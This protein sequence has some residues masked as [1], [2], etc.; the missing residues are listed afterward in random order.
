MQEVIKPLTSECVRICV[1][2]I[3]TIAPQEVVK[4]NFQMKTSPLTI[5]QTSSPPLKFPPQT[6]K[7]QNFTRSGPTKS[8]ISYKVT[9]ST[10]ERPA[11]ISVLRCARSV[12]SPIITSIPICG[13]WT[14]LNLLVD[15]SALG[16]NK[17]GTFM[18]LKIRLYKGCMGKV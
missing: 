18:I 4:P 10:T 17:P 5:L 11:L 8:W 14:S 1:E 12:Q 2:S 16:V 15:I 13:L 6:S 3:P 9:K 7:C